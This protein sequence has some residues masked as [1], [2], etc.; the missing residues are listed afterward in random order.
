MDPFAQKIISFEERKSFG[1]AS[2]PYASRY[3]RGI[4][5]AG[6]SGVDGMGLFFFLFLPA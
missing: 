6:L 4:R 5:L 2:I 1:E 3:S